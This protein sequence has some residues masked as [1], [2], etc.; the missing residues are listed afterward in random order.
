[1]PAI[2]NNRAAEHPAEGFRSAL[3]P[4]AGNGPVRLYLPTDYQPKYAY[5]LV[6]LFHADGECEEHSAR[7]VP[8]LSRRNYIVLCL[9]GPVNLGLRADGRPAFGWSGAASNRGSK[10]ALAYATS[11]YSVHPDRV[12][13]LGVGEGATAAY[14]LGLELGDRVAGVVALNGE[15]P[16]GRLPAS[17][18][19]VLIG[20]GT[21]NPVVPVAGARRA[22]TELTRSGATVRV[23]R[24][25]TSH[26]VHPDML[27]DA[28]RWIMQQIT[29]KQPARGQ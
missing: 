28:N 21:A 25:A 13:L 8:Q 5:P 27:G 16:K 12:F 19:R 4:A 24:Y 1:M 11:R 22:A 3:L 23:T 2:K 15:L 17:K 9:R 14:R 7:L 29:E 18:L 26:R 10:A 6:V 20:H